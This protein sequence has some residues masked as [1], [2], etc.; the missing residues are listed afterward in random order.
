MSAAPSPKRDAAR[1][2]DARIKRAEARIL[3]GA[4]AYLDALKAKATEVARGASDDEL[5]PCAEAVEAAF[6]RYHGLAIELGE[7]E[8]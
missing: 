1:T 2:R 5:K 7:A 4:R 3:E 8:K 6:W